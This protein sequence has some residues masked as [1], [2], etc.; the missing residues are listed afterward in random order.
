MWNF[1]ISFLFDSLEMYRAIMC[2]QN[3]L[4]FIQC[5]GKQTLRERQENKVPPGSAQYTLQNAP[6]QTFCD[7]RGDTRLSMWN[8]WID[9]CLTHL[10]FKGASWVDR[11]LFS[12][13]SV[14]GRKTEKEGAGILPICVC[15]IR[16]FPWSCNGASS[17]VWMQNSLSEGKAILP[18]LA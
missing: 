13:F 12:S 10:T 5:Y 16:C 4:E 17:T 8:F 15:N 9:V 14:H 6:C 1:L 7:Q 18:S 2:A 3:S 11:I